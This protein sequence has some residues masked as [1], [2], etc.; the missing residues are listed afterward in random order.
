MVRPEAGSETSSDPL[1]ESEQS[2]VGWWLGWVLF[3]LLVVYPLSIGPAARVHMACPGARPAIETF[4]TPLVVLAKSNKQV[5]RFF[6]WYISTVWK[7]TS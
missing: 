3:F 5:A 7:A 4:Y 1:G 6:S 2:R